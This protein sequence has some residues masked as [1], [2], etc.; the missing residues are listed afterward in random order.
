MLKLT[1]PDGTVEKIRKGTNLIAL[2]RK[3]SGNYASPIAEALFNGCEIDLQRPLEC[4]GT[5]EFIEMNTDSGM[6]VFV[7]SLFFACIAATRKLFPE[8]NLEARNSLGSALYVVPHGD[9][10][11]RADIHLIEKEMRR[12]IDENKK[13][14]L[15]RLTRTQAI[16][17]AR[18]NGNYEDRRGILSLLPED[19][20]T[21]FFANQLSGCREYFFGALLPSLG[22]C[23]AFELIRFEQGFVINYPETGAYDVLPPWDS[24]RR[25]NSIYS[26]AEEW[27]KLLNCNTIGKLNELIAE[28]RANRIIQ[29]SEALQE[30]RI[31][32]I[33]DMIAMHKELRI[34]LIAGPSSSG[35]TSFA[36]RLS[37]QLAVN[38]LQ[39]RALSMDDYYVPRRLTPRKP[40]GSYDYECVE[41]I[42]IQLFNADLQ[43]L[44]RGDEVLLPR[45]NFKLGEREYSGKKIRLGERGVLVIEGIHG[46]NEKLTEKIPAASKLK[47]YI[48]ALT[49][50]SLDDHN[51]L[52]TTDMRMLRRLVRDNQFRGHNAE[53]TLEMW[54]SVREGEEKYIFPFQEQADVFFN[55]SLI[56]EAAVLRSYAEPLL[57]A[58]KSNA[59]GYMIACRM[60]KILRMIRPIGDISVIPNNSIMREFVGGSVFKDVL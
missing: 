49:P 50:M 51:R 14:R 42:D 3:Y 16:A 27:S 30:K 57:A 15:C 46:L 55:T 2:S 43:K 9:S 7:R 26:E 11:S 52:N 48:S 33:A 59:S 24:N 1:M 18:E 40:D 36:Q 39:P 6:R 12:M 47:I 58:I 13:I 22:S 53:A 10:L 35:K 41:A 54:S 56:Y 23:K 60:L 37:I 44:L 21:D 19:E 5:V 17:M 25:I 8:V 31:A 38:G 4:D 32:Q 45:Y 34:V 28:G 20:E 29:L